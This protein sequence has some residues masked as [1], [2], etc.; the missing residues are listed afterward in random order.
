[1]SVTDVFDKDGAEVAARGCSELREG[2]VDLVPLN[3]RLTDGSASEI[4]RAVV[5]R[6]DR[7]ARPAE[8]HV[9]L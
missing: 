1:M 6:E 7:R 4:E 8:V 9:C 5:G 3:D 2:L